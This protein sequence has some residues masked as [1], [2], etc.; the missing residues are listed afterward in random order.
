MTIARHSNTVEIRP[1]SSH[2]L[3]SR[4]IVALSLTRVGYCHLEH[5]FFRVFTNVAQDL[6]VVALDRDKRHSIEASTEI[7]SIKDVSFNNGIRAVL[8]N[9]NHLCCDTRANGVVKN[10]VAGVCIFTSLVIRT[11]INA[12]TVARPFSS[13]VHDGTTDDD[14]VVGAV[15]NVDGFTGEITDHAAINFAMVC[16]LHDNTL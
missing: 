1:K 16:S 2:A 3:I 13:S 15:L 8:F 14:V 11:E 6:I 5:I 10:V 12:F 7:A 9:I 4:E